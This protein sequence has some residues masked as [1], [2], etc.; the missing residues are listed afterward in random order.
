MASLITL[1]SQILKKVR[2][3]KCDDDYPTQIA[4]LSSIRVLCDR[5]QE[6]H[7]SQN[8]KYADLSW[9]FRILCKY[10]SDTDSKIR[11]EASFCLA[12]LVKV[13]GPALVVRP[14]YFILVMESE[15]GGT[16]G[17]AATG[18]KTKAA[19][20][21]TLTYALLTFPKED[22]HNLEEIAGWVCPPAKSRMKYAFTVSPSSYMLN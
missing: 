22:F 20:I 8:L 12:R 19:A 4:C 15:S 3:N 5:L 18:A 16:E 21:D 1:I 14:I 10:S 2:K 6:M 17:K 13:A 11:P 7:N 9:L